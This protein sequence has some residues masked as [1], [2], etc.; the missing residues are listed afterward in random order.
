MGL[1]VITMVVMLFVFGVVMVAFPALAASASGRTLDL[2][3]ESL[4]RT[5][6]APISQGVAIG[7][8]YL[9]ASMVARLRVRIV[10]GC[11]ELRWYHIILS[12]SVGMAKYDL[13]RAHVVVDFNRKLVFVTEGER[14]LCLNLAYLYRRD[15]LV[16]AVLMASVSTH[17]PG[18]LSEDEDRDTPAA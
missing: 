1:S 18:A 2:S 7:A 16:R 11:I 13:A 17:L 8:G 9:A 6:I 4:F 14:E 5:P 15:D 12:R 10:P 3:L